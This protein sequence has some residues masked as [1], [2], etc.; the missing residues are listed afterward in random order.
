MKNILITV[1]KVV[2][3]LLFLLAAVVQ[4]W[5]ILAE[6]AGSPSLVSALTSPLEFR[7]KA[8]LVFIAVLSLCSAAILIRTLLHRQSVLG[9]T[10]FS[11][12]LLAVQGSLFMHVVTV[13]MTR[14]LAH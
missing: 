14:M 11:A 8:I 6:F 7:W 5:F 13:Q 2:S 10:I 4:G 1:S 12:I 3:W 9:P